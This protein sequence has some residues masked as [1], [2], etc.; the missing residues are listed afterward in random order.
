MQKELYLNPCWGF[1]LMKSWNANHIRTLQVSHPSHRKGGRALEGAG[2]FSFD[3]GRINSCLQLYIWL[4]WR[5]AHLVRKARNLL[6]AQTGG[7]SSFL[8]ASGYVI[9]L[10]E[11][12]SSSRFYLWRQL[13]LL[14]WDQVAWPLPLW[15]WPLAPNQKNKRKSLSRR[16]QNYWSQWT[17]NV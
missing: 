4:W 11:L 7:I 9:L 13:S 8:V 1:C 16:L 17:L 10:M 14:P 15:N 12:C 3:A 2:R 5:I 6:P